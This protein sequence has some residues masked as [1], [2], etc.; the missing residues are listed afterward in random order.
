MFAIAMELLTGRYTATRFNDRSE[1][2]WPPHPA[3][4]F[5]AMVAAWA[6]DDD[7]GPDEREALRWLEE[8][9][10]PDICCGDVRRRRV[11]T[12][13][14]PVNDATALSR[15]LSRTYLA[16]ADAGDALR[17]AER[18]GDERAARRAR[19]ALAK[20]EAKA[21]AD[22]AKAG[23]PA[24]RESAAVAASVQ[25]VLPEFR[26]KQGRTYPTV[27]PDEP[28]VW[29][30]WPEAEPSA[31]HRGALDRLLARVG[32]VGHSSTLVSCRVVSS[33]PSPTWVPARAG[34]FFRDDIRRLRVPRT[35]LLGRLELAYA[36][37]R[38]REPRSLPAGMVGYR[39]PSA[40]PARRVSPL[41][42]GDWYVLGVASQRPLSI[43]Q[44]LT[45][46]RAV[47]SAL[48][49]HGEQPPPPI[50]SGHRPAPD[51]HEGPTPPLDQPHLAVVPLPNVSA[52]HRY[53]D[54]TVFGIALVLPAGCSED[55]RA[56]VE[57]A[58]RSWSA[59][60]FELLLPGRPGGRPVRL[61]LED[62]GID[63]AF[64]QGPGWL[65]ATLAP[66]RR[67]TTRGYWCRPAR[68][69]LTV[70]PIALD[71]F[72]GKLRSPDP[73]ARDRAEDE[74]M[75]SIVRACRYAGLI[76][77][78]DLTVRLDSPLVGVPAAPSGPRSDGAPRNRRFP[79][80]LTGSGTPRVCVHAEIEFPEPVNGPV[81][82]GAGRH[83]G[84]GLCIPADTERESR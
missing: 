28:T 77:P 59:A 20:A 48:L 74:A 34:S 24:G 26:G 62:L 64:D 18:S 43:T 25:A 36:S 83:F 69:W 51:G 32:R 70:T 47:R 56:A 68:R 11:V 2:E 82:I 65:E 55:D 35:G 50:I 3:R 46:A 58:L 38:G 66:R 49:A 42:S 5:S 21:I 4:L 81:L 54:G 52:G 57:R 7:P 8:Q 19:T 30:V 23:R 71:R 76:E 73:A 45:V 44:T 53:G 63:R 84:Y 37:H 78:S 79:G 39:R 41:L 33:A 27:V 22:A 80:Y 29:F 17:A 40:A 13:Y 16:M 72:P 14:V 67:T 6:D 10:P 9:G 12:H 61:T 15:D 1:A 31:G 60:G 75:A